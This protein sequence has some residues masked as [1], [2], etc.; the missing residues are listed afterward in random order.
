MSTSPYVYGIHDPGGEH[1]LN[2]RGWIVFTE[3][4][5]SA[6]GDYRRY[7]DAGLGVIVRLN[8][9]YGNGV[10]CIPT[11]DKYADFAQK[12]AAW[13]AASRG[14]EWL[15]IGNEIALAH[16]WPTQQPITLASYANCYRQCYDAIK[17]VAPNVK[18]APQAVAPWNDSTP[19]APDWI[20]QLATMLNMLSSRV[21]WIALH[22]YTRGYGLDS[23]A[24]GA[25]MSPPYAHRHSGWETLFEFMLAIP[26]NM[27]QLPAMITEVNGNAPWATYQRGWLQEMY[28]EIEAWNGT[29]GNQQIRAA[30]LFRWARHD[31]RWDMSQ[32]SQSH[33]DLR[34]AVSRGYRWREDVPS[35]ATWTGYVTAQA[36]VNLRT[37]P[38]R[39]APVI[40]SVVYG[41]ALA[42]H[43]GTV[44]DGTWYAVTYA[45]QQDGYV[46]A[47]WVSKEK[48][49]AE[50]EP[51][52]GRDA[53]VAKLSAEYGI[54]PRLAQAVIKVESGGAAFHDD[55]VTMRFEP[56]VFK[57]RFDALFAEYFQLGDPQWDGGQHRYNDNGTWK[58]FHGDQSAEYRAQRLATHIARWAAME[59]AS[60][61]LGQIMGF[62]YRACGYDSAES[63]AAAFQSSED[64]QVK[65]MFEY[66]RHSGALDCL[67]AGDL[68]GFARIYNGPAQARRYADLISGA[69]R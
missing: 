31:T 15:V 17:A 38:D 34:D 23:F 66:F 61:G 2:G 65:A 56:H 64:A 44:G 53:I 40:R 14:V 46:A 25:K 6:P 10:G 8:N 21:D 49:V 5:D 24:T 19:D 3:T 43:G 69:M 54:D 7:I 67:R 58:A 42:V 28:R 22:A 26:Q 60:Y 12:C 36:G 27:R 4:A 51:A 57:S 39:Q 9:G 20:T 32:C 48:P 45:G 52:T 37:R 63:M 16:E 50:A 55:L 59:S 35:A 13:V 18:I 1:L 33:D 47:A 11:P 30:C 68:V 62:N 41:D 29:K